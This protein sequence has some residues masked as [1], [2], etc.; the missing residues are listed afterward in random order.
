MPYGGGKKKETDNP[1]EIFC[2]FALKASYLL[3]APQPSHTNYTANTRANTWECTIPS[4]SLS[5]PRK[6]TAKAVPYGGGKKKETDNL[7]EI[8]CGFAL[9]ASYLLSAPQ[10]SHTNYTANTRANTWEC[11]IPSGSLSPPRKSTAKAVPY[12]GGD[13]EIRTRGLYVANV[14]LYQL[15]HIPINCTLIIA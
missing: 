14:P 9:K 15:S 13:N 7:N 12:G 2:G 1:N 5:P 3:S 8:F 4:G 6:S 10:P 11:T